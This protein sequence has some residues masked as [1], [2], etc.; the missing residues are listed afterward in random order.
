MKEQRQSS[1]KPNSDCS[2]SIAE[3]VLVAVASKGFVFCFFTDFVRL[4]FKLQLGGRPYLITNY[5]DSLLVHTPQNKKRKKM[6]LKTT[7]ANRWTKNKRNARR[8][9]EKKKKKKS[10]HA[11]Q[12]SVAESIFSN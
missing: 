8:G 2:A 11:V 1:E 12:Q 7:E 4:S 10:C 6:L 3:N 5:I 9:G